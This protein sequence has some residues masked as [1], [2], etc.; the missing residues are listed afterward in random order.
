MIWLVSLKK[1][2][3]LPGVRY[4]ACLTG[5]KGLTIIYFFPFLNIFFYFRFNILFFALIAVTR[6]T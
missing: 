4:I 5:L 3:L 1:C 2:P 6:S